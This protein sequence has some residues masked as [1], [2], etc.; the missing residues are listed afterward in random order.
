TRQD[1]RKQPIHRP[2]NLAVQLN[3]VSALAAGA[4]V[5]RPRHR[6]GNWSAD[7]HIRALALHLG[8]PGGR[9][10]PRSKGSFR[11]RVLATVLALAG[12]L[13]FRSAV[14]PGWANPS[15]DRF[16][17][18][19][20]RGLDDKPYG[21]LPRAWAHYKG[22]YLHGNTVVLAYTVGSAEILDSPAIERQG[23]IAV[24]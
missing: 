16:N 22:L 3:S 1:S 13:A 2:V 18:P 8:C 10:H 19:R 11:K 9:G 21:P 6:A 14:A 5:H 12:R 15:D 4:S 7:A 24:F 20:L 17:E 23:E